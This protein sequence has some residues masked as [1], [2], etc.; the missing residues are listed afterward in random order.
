MDTHQQS[1]QVIA[2]LRQEGLSVE[3]QTLQDVID[4]GST[5]GEIVMGLR[6]HLREVLPKATATTARQIRELLAALP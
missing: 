1:L 6:F 3:A 4:G 2:A 5:G